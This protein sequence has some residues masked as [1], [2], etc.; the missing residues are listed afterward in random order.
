MPSGLLVMEIFY[1]NFK[2]RK[3][4]QQK[5]F[6][7]YRRD[8][9]FKQTLVSELSNVAASKINST[10]YMVKSFHRAAI[11]LLFTKFYD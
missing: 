3:S 8:K 5:S 4:S 7:I 6:S 10:I 11:I 1:F 9:N 2:I